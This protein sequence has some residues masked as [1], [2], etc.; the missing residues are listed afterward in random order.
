MSTV[1]VAAGVTI[2]RGQP[3]A[4]I[5][6]LCVVESDDVMFV[7][8]E[9]LV[10]M[11][12]ARRL[13][14]IFKSSYEKDNRTIGEAYR[15]PGLERGLASLAAIKARFGCPLL[16][17]VHRPSDVPAAAQVVEVLQVPALLC[18]Q[19]SLL[20]AVGAAGRV[21][22]LKKGQ[23]MS[24]VGLAGSVGKLRG[25]G[26]QAVLVT[27]RGSSF[28]YDRLVC[29]LAGLGELQALGC[30]VVVDA[31]HASNQPSEI[32]PLACAGVAAGADAL[33]V[34][35]HPDPANARSDDRRMLSL[36]QLEALLPRIV[37]IAEALR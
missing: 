10:A 37:R 2:G 24:P 14:L 33:F 12:A 19:T 9:R 35:C 8:A 25:A 17:D 34:E 36:D 28:G 30:P 31:G 11:A 18:R 15:G 3:L 1:S 5:A 29:D 16:T 21:V 27:E 22:N 23:F 13:P 7:A 6:G 32:A 4:L 20:E 26:A